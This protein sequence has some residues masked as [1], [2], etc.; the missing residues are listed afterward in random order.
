VRDGRHLG[1]DEIAEAYRTTLRR[2]A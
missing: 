2:L 1:R